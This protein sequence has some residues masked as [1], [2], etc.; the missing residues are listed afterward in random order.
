MENNIKNLV[1][2][3]NKNGQVLTHQDTAKEGVSWYQCSTFI[4]NKNVLVKGEAWKKYE[5]KRNAMIVLFDGESGDIVG[6]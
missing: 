5:V 4:R 2:I 1:K 3:D 6:G